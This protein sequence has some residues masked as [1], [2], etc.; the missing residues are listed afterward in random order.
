MKKNSTYHIIYINCDCGSSH[1]AR[2]TM[3]WI[4]GPRCPGCK[5]I[6]GG[7]DFDIVGKVKAIG[8]IP[9]LEKYRRNKCQ[10]TKKQ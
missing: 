8:E 7:M 9:A 6:V 4:Y 5:R 10:K 3:R 2:K 1:V